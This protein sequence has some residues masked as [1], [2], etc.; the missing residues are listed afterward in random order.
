MCFMA[1]ANAMYAAMLSSIMMEQYVVAYFWLVFFLYLHCARGGGCHAALYGAGGTLVTSFFFLPLLSGESPFQKTKQWFL[2]MVRAAAF[3]VF[4]LLA[5]GRFDVIFG[6]PQKI[7]QLTAYTGEHVPFLEKIR[8]YLTFVK[9]CFFAPKAGVVEGAVASWQ[10]AGVTGLD[11]LGILIL[12]LALFGFFVG[13][14]KTVA[15]IAFSWCMLSFVI[16][17]V[18]GW[19][20]AENGLIL[21]A[22]YFGWAFLLLLFQLADWVGERWQKAYASL[23]FCILLS[24]VMVGINLWGLLGLVQFAE[25]YYPAVL[26][27]G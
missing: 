3:F 11:F 9:A 23:V 21:Y 16:L 15:R 1:A 14:K 13:R 4:L 25:K 6:L 24:L 12:C 5:F 2:G 10:L 17:C 19:G 26:I 7:T 22:L 8:Q 27:R 20:T 18:F